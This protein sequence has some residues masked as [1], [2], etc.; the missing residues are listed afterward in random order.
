MKKNFKVLLVAVF[1]AIASCNV[2][3]GL[4]NNIESYI[5]GGQ[6]KNT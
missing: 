2:E 4:A 5:C 3:T 6:L 1:V